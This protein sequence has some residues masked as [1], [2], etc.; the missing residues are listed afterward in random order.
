M[1]RGRAGGIVGD[2]SL[3]PSACS[4]DYPEQPCCR[5]EA[6]GESWRHQTVLAAVAAATPARY[7]IRGGGGEAAKPQRAIALRWTERWLRGRV[8]GGNVEPTSLA[9]LSREWL[10]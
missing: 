6:V 7:V 8:G 1:Q 3:V 10:W 9:P 5:S 2:E 4:L